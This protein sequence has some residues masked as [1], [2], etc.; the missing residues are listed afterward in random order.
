MILISLAV[1][2]TILATVTA[3]VATTPAAVV[4]IAVAIAIPSPAKAVRKVDTEVISKGARIQQVPAVF[5][6][7]VA[8]TSTQPVTVRCHF[9]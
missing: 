8:V 1:A 2:V 6:N 4:A 9:K 7:S 3:A 5:R